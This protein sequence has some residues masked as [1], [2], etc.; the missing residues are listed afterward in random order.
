MAGVEGYFAFEGDGEI[1][2]EA[3]FDEGGGGGGVLK[4]GGDAAEGVD[5][6]G[7]AGVGGAEHGAAE[8][9]G[10]EAGVVEV[11]LGFV[12]LKEPAVVGDVGEDLRAGADELAGDAADGVFEAD[13]GDQVDGLFFC[14]VGCGFADGGGEGL[15]G[16]AGAEVAR[17]EVAKEGLHEG[18]LVAEGEVFAEGDE[19]LFVGALLVVKAAVEE[20]G[21][22]V[23]LVGFFGA[24]ADAGEEGDV[25]FAQD[26]G[27]EVTME[28]DGFG[29]HVE[30]DGDGI[31]RPDDEVD[32]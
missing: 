18:E 13:E 28:V 23:E 9:D 6:A 3:A 17:E 31:F 14:A 22:V 24:G 32:G 4:L 26:G 21:A 2:G 20:D 27:E 15:G 5:V 1:G 11:D 8:F 10:A 29:I 19:V 12:T 16:G 7:D 25:A 30:H